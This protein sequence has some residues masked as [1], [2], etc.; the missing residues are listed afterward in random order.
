MSVVHRHF[1]V[2]YQRPG[3]IQAPVL[4]VQTMRLLALW[5]PARSGFRQLP[6][7]DQLALTTWA[8]PLPA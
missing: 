8:V 3:G 7:G 5:R 4:P 6:E 2:I 1:S